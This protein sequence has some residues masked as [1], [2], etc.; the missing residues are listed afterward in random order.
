M[1]WFATI[2]GVI[3]AIL[4]VAVV[5]ILLLAASKPDEFSVERSA[6]INAPPEKIFPLINDLHAWKAWSPWENKDPN[7]Q[8]TFSDNTVG[9]GATYAWKGDK[10]VGEGSMEITGATPNSRI[11]IALRFLK[12]FK[13]ESSVEFTL[14]PSG[15]TTNVRWVMQGRQIFMGKV[16]CL[17]MNMDNMVGKDF[18][19]GLASMKAAAEK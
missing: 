12:P 17:F 9:E 5:V 8:R 10:N 16:M 19:A 14:E 11:A 4:I 6:Q 3:V 13:S 18:E 15:N 2:A 7:M 1:F